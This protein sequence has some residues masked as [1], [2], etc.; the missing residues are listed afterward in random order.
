MISGVVTSDREATI[1]VLVRGARGQEAEV[2]AVIDTGFTGF[3]T[4]P[5]RLIANLVLSF[6][7]TTRAALADGSEVAM[8]VFEASVLWDDLE[9]DVVVLAAEGVA[10]VGM[11]LLSGYRVTLEVESGGSVRIEALSGA[12]G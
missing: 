5:A 11:A 7:G 3:L 4:L 9:H 12:A 2:E 1:R 10:L 8:D 6:A